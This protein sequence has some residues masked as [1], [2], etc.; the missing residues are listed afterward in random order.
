MSSGVVYLTRI[1]QLV[2]HD[3][4]GIDELTEWE[5]SESV[6]QSIP[7]AKFRRESWVLSIVAKYL[8][9]S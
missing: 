9:L 7:A 1:T 4:C 5:Y 8:W 2:R 6:E 3:Y